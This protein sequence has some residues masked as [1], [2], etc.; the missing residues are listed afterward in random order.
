MKVQKKNFWTNN[1]K[2]CCPLGLFYLTYFKNLRTLCTNKQ[3]IKCTYQTLITNILPV[4]LKATLYKFSLFISSLISF[5]FSPNLQ[6]TYW[7]T[8]HLN[9]P[10]LFSKNPQFW[11]LQYGA[12]Y[13]F[14]LPPW[15]D[16]C[17]LLVTFF[18]PFSL[19]LKH[20]SCCE[21]LIPR[22]HKLFS[23]DWITYLKFL[24]TSTGILFF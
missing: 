14:V 15:C 13:T 1:S 20:F 23:Q 11:D 4:S 3:K 5:K 17:F 21:L 10:K 18:F 8:I 19:L 24:G 12:H 2:F 6:V 7:N 22:A 9:L 16:Y